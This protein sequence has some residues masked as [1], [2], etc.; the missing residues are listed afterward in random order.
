MCLACV[1]SC[2]CCVYAIELCSL[3]RMR[4]A[5]KLCGGKNWRRQQQQQQEHTDEK[6][7]NNLKRYSSLKVGFYVV[8]WHSQFKCKRCVCTL[9]TLHIRTNTNVR[10]Q[11]LSHTHRKPFLLIESS[12]RCCEALPFT[13]QFWINICCCCRCRYGV[14]ICI[15]IHIQVNGTLLFPFARQF[16]L[17]GIKFLGCPCKNSRSRARKKDHRI[18][19]PP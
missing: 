1:C 10:A 11:T 7:K 5:G 15:A 14:V 3:S 2:V 6:E 13:M 16:H 12:R 8:K 4:M 18:P 17:D 19:E 9:P